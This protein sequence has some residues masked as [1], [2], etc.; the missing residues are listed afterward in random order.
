MS[1]SPLK[2]YIQKAKSIPIALYLLVMTNII[3]F[4]GLVYKELTVFYMLGSLI[5]VI[6]MITTIG[7]ATKMWNNPTEIISENVKLRIEEG[8]LKLKEVLYSIDLKQN[9]S[10]SVSTLVTVITFK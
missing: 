4:I 2:T 10:S 6:M 9:N 5:F 8:S 7:C 1:E 3:L